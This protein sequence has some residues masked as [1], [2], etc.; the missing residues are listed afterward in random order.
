MTTPTL[1][2]DRLREL[3][4]LRSSYNAFVGGRYERRSVPD[5]APT[6][7]A[8]SGAARHVSMG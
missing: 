4:D 2:R 8:R 3:F 5:L 7:R 6:A 1:D